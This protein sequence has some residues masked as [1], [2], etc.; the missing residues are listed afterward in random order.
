MTIRNLYINHAKERYEIVTK[1][2]NTIWVMV[3]GL[4]TWI[5]SLFSSHN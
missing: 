1:K 2:R 5:Y 3:S 4:V